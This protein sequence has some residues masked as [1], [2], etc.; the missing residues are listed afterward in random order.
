MRSFQPLENP[1][2]KIVYSPKPSSPKLKPVKATVT[3]EILPAFSKPSKLAE[4]V[5]EAQKRKRLRRDYDSY[6]S[7]ELSSDDSE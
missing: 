1:K 2:A 3:R 4:K 5:Q 6:E 7:G